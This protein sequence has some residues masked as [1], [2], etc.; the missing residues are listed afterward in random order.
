VAVLDVDYHHGNGTQDIFYQRDDV[1]TV[2]IHGHPRFAYPYFSG[3][4]EETGEGK[5]LGFNRNYPMPEILDGEGYRRVL[6]RALKRIQKFNP[7]FL[8]LALGLDTVKND[9]TGTWSLSAADLKLNGQMIGALQ[10]PTVVVQEGGYRSR[11]LGT[12]AR[13][14]FLG[15]W[16]SMHAS[17]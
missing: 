5:G 1:L 14:F 16:T 2:S 8:I 7:Q 17:E 6:E 10:L 4:S 13:N 11:S 3:F 15:L 12:N 9:P